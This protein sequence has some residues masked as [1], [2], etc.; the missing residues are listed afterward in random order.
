MFKKIKIGAN[1]IKAKLFNQKKPLSITFSI[2]NKCN[3]RCSYC[4]LP[5]RK[6]KELS[7]NQALKL[8]DEFAKAGAQ[9]VSFVG[10]EPL[11][12][13]DIGL[14]IEKV[15]KKNMFVSIVTNGTLIKKNISSLK[16]L[17]I[18]IISIDGPQEVHNLTG[19]AN[20]SEL[21]ENIRLLK[22]NKINISTSTVLTKPTIKHLDYLL[23]ISKE[24]KFNLFFQPY[25]HLVYLSLTKTK[26]DKLAPS[27]NEFKK[28]IERIIKE[29]K[30]GALIANSFPYL[31]LIKD[32]TNPEANKCLAGKRYCYIDTNGDVYP[33]SPMI[34]RMPV[35]N[36]VKI[37]FKNAF[38]KM[39]NFSCKDG[40]IFPCYQEYNLLFSLSLKSLS[41]IL[42]VLKNKI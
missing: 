8:I 25:S 33:C 42:K 9:K 29:K 28:A 20:V 27:L 31:N 6:Q 12:R 41:N 15:K 39:P 24:L 4:S 35:Y 40:C 32:G 7:T 18:I 17:D 19:K 2:T 5:E 34:E 1:I 26:S 14:L 16:N 13:E 37:G 10:G 36:T 3:L 30:K 23:K 22:K 21:L 11:L 38:N